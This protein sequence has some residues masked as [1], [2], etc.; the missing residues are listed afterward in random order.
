MFPT[1]QLVAHGVKYSRKMQNSITAPRKLKPGAL[2][3]L[4]LTATV[5]NLLYCRR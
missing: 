3:A 2:T 5:E 1:L 4:Q